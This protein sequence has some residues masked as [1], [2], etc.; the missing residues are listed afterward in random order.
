MA[1]EAKSHRANF[2][3]PVNNWLE[4]CG[5]GVEGEKGEV[6]ERAVVLC[7]GFSRPCVVSPFVRHS[8]YSHHHRSYQL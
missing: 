5:F 6:G 7:H 1:V 8:L 3:Q 4:A 2:D